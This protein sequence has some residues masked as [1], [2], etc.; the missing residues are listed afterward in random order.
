MFRLLERAPDVAEIS[1]CV[2]AAG[3][4]EGCALVLEGPAGIGKTALLTVTC[5][6]ARKAGMAILTARAGELETGLPWGVVHGLFEPELDRASRAEQQDLLP[7]A[8]VA[9]ER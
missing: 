4:G 5:D 9:G 6:E 7:G 8:L 2:R 1:R 3:A